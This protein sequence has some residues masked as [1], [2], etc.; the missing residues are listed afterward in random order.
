MYVVCDVVLGVYERN[1][2][3]VD[4]AAVFYASADIGDRKAVRHTRVLW[5]NE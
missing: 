5:Q 2:Q 3:V 1:G 4:F